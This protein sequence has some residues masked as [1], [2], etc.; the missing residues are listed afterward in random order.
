MQKKIGSMN[1]KL[2]SII[3]ILLATVCV[4]QADEGE[5]IYARIG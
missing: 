2:L 5:A 3:F 1:R 4:A